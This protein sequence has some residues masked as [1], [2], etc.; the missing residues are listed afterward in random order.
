MSAQLSF[1]TMA[2]PPVSRAKCMDHALAAGER[3]M[4]RAADNAERNAP[5]WTADALELVRKFARNQGGALFT[6]EA[7]RWVIQVELP[8]PPDL[9]SW[10]SVTRLATKRGYIAK[11]KRTAPTVSSNGSDRPLYVRGPKA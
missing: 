8:T 4:E 9:R 2:L 11:T 6:V 5:G 10:G 7:M 1:E 3:G